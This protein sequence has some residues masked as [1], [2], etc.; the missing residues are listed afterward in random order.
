M[1]GKIRNM[2]HDRGFGFIRFEANGDYFFHRSQC[3]TPFED[4]R[5]ND[6]VEFELDENNA[7]GPRAKNIRL[8]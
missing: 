2:V 3:I 4:M 5:V 1:T 8:V 7:K 6:N